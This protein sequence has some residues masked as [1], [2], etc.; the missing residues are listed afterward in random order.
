MKTT[1]ETLLL[2]TIVI[3]I[4]ASSCKQREYIAGVENGM[5]YQPPQ[6]IQPYKAESIEIFDNLFYV[7][8]NGDFL[9]YENAKFFYNSNGRIDSISTDYPI[10]LFHIPLKKIEVRGM[11]ANVKMPKEIRKKV[12]LET[13]R[14]IK[15][16][17][18]RLNLLN[19][20]WIAFTVSSKKVLPSMQIRS[21]GERL[22]IVMVPTQNMSTV[23][24]K[25]C[26]NVYVY[27][28]DMY[29]LLPQFLKRSSHEI[30]RPGTKFT[31]DFSEKKSSQISQVS[32]SSEVS[33]SKT[34]NYYI[35]KKGDSLWKISEKTKISYK[36]LITLND[37]NKTLHL[38]DKVRLK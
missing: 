6:E 9:F 17:I 11:K 27:S 31:F 7:K 24:E 19:K 34:N 14:D 36:K 4:V 1:K 2:I 3:A 21:E 16:P 33:N 15:I 38:G 35:V 13:E 18:E 23:V 25:G 8:N 37:P 32:K 10:N 12:Y 29:V 20:N 5:N 26:K 22:L 28:D 30:W